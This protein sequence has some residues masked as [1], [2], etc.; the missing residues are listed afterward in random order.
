MAPL[1]LLVAI[2]A[3]A[4]DYSS[5]ADI[6]AFWIFAFVFLVAAVLGLVG[7]VYAVQRWRKL[8]PE[9]EAYEESL[10]LNS[11]PGHTDTVQAEP[12]SHPGYSN[13]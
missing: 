13:V 6:V 1:L 3:M 9:I 10:P 12:Y 5:T 7:T 2:S 11:T 8:K 4:D